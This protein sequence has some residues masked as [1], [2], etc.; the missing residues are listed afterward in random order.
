MDTAFW[1]KPNS[2]GFTRKLD[3]TLPQRHTIRLYNGL[4][5]QESAIIIQLRTDHKRL[6]KYLYRQKLADS[7]QCECGQ[8]EDSTE[9]L[10]LECPNW[11]AERR[12]LRPKMDARWG[13]LS[14]MLGG[15]SLK[16][17]RVR[18]W[19]AQKK[20]RPSVSTAKAA[21]KFVMATKKLTLTL[22]NETEGSVEDRRREMEGRAAGATQTY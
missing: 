2:W 3:G 19:T 17:R 20:W 5:T 15:W 10:L 18:P 22:E 21:I 8:N 6:R 13:D 9:H 12:I 4:S 7:D 1:E 11:E 16:G 14:Y